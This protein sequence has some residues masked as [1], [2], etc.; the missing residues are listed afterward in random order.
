MTNVSVAN[1]IVDELENYTTDWDGTPMAGEAEPIDGLHCSTLY[2]AM[3][4]I[5]NLRI[6]IEELE[7][8]KSI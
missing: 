8:I 7:E 1:D 2:R 5:I 4:T 6:R 3:D